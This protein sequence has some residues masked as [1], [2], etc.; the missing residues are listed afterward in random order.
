MGNADEHHAA[1][2]R[3]AKVGLRGTDARTGAASVHQPA[4]A[5]RPSVAVATSDSHVASGRQAFDTARM[6]IRSVV[7]MLPVT[8]MPKSIAF[9]ARLGFRVSSDFVPPG[10]PAPSWVWLDAHGERGKSG[11]MLMLTRANG[12]LSAGARTVL[13]VYADDIAATHTELAAEG[14]AVGPL[15]KRFYAAKGEF[16]VEDPDGHVLMVTHL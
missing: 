11:G 14:V 16:R 7:A 3:N 5:A 9:Y 4:R 13:Y 12:A 15:E 2:A 6:A 1:S 8:D 10:A